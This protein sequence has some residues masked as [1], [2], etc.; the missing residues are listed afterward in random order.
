[1]PKLSLGFWVEVKVL[2]SMVAVYVD[3]SIPTKDYRAYLLNR[4]L[5]KSMAT[6]M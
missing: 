5:L 4:A 2:L 1:M 3:Y 6:L